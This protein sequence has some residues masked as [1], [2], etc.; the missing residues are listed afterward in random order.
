MGSSYPSHLEVYDQH[1]RTFYTAV[2]QGF[3]EPLVLSLY[4]LVGTL[5]LAGY[6]LLPP[7]SLAIIRYAR[8]PVFGIYTYTCI[9]TL[10]S[11]RTCSHAVSYILGAA[12]A[13]GPLWA[14]KLLVFSDARLEAR[15]VEERIARKEEGSSLAN[16]A[17]TSGADGAARQDLRQRKPLAN[18]S[19]QLGDQSSESKIEYYWQSCP[20]DFRTRAG[21]IVDLS[22]ALRGPGWAHQ[23]RTIPGPPSYITAT[24]PSPPRTSPVVAA[25]PTRSAILRYQ[26]YMF[27]SRFIALDI[28]KLLLMH[29]PYF[30]GLGPNAPLP[31]YFPPFLAAHPT[32]LRNVRLFTCFIAVRF[33][34]EQVYATVTLLCCGLLGPRLLGLRAAP[35]YYPDFYG[36]VSAVATRG[37]AGF[38]GAHWHQLLR[39][40]L[41]APGA[42]IVQ[43]AG[44]DARDPKAK[45]VTAVMAFVSS[46]AMHACASRMMQGVARPVGGSFTFFVLQI[47]GLVGEAVLVEAVKR[48]GVRDRVPAHVRE[49]VS[50]SVVMAWLLWTSPLFTDDVASTGIFLFEPC[51][52][53]FVRVLG[54]GGSDRNWWRWKGRNVFWYSDPHHWYKSGLAI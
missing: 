50:F 5:L 25:R 32:V 45:F 18:G 17:G 12:F 10:L 30:L 41:E 47:V 13:F 53:S 48:A 52:I 3:Y 21:W 4:R 6:L 20:S 2:A 11:A 29:D 14:S 15:R 22:L 24:L 42:G 54:F 39:A 16:G 9:D 1:V 8:F 27:I 37:L 31:P 49:G 36:P 33:A 28:F 34:L 40:G 35:H 51:P 38:W 46:G 43:W 7:S 19:L 26:L 44:W 23:I